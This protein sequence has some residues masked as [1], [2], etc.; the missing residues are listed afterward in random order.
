[1]TFRVEPESVD[2]YSRQLAELAQAVEAARSY[3]NKWGTF[4]AH[5]KGIL[6]MLHGKHGSFMTE[7]NEVLERLSRTADASSMNLSASA[8]YFERT[9]H[10]SA[11]E[12]DDSYP[13]VQRPIT[14]AGS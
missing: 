6:G 1:M 12:L 2:L 10:Q 11:T 5:G 8:R 14:T 4:S 9:D 7:L 13:S 3:A